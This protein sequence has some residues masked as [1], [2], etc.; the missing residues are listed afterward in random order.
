[1]T[2]VF[3]SPD[4]IR[5]EEFS[6]HYRF[7]RELLCPP[8]LSPRTIIGPRWAIKGRGGVQYDKCPLLIK[9]VRCLLTH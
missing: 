1:M 8:V 7:M 4:R 6:L 2:F 3:V 5:N 9:S